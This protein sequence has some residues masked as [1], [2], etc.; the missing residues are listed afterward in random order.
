MLNDLYRAVVMEHAKNKRNY[1]RLVGGKVK[2]IY[3]KNPTCGDLITLYIQIDQERIEEVSFEG[4][5]CSISMASSSMMTEMIKGKRINEVIVQMNEF[6][7]L[8]DES[9]DL[10][11]AQ[12]L[13]GVHKLRARHNCAL[14]SWQ[15]LE[16]ILSQE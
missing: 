4:V 11:D 10:G 2:S 14:M 12:S 16:R 9:I 6:E 15:A 8:E 3:Y 13:E 7:A 5:G 1:G